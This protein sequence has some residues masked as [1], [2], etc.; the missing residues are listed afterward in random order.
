MCI[1]TVSLK[2]LAVKNI[3]SQGICRVR[4]A[5]CCRGFAGMYPHKGGNK[6]DPLL[7]LRCVWDL[8]PPSLTCPALNEMLSLVAEK[9]RRR[10]AASPL[11]AADLNV[12][13][14]RNFTSLPRVSQI[15]VCVCAFCPCGQGS[16]SFLHC[17]EGEIEEPRLKMYEKG[18]TSPPL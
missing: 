10:E 17:L 11:K 13:K 7:I 9:G 12:M 15:C 8:K 4:D 2:D 6:R 3:P 1:T 14:R 18:V 5:L 16:F